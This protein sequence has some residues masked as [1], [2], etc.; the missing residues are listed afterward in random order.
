MKTIHR[1][2]FDRRVPLDKAEST[3]TLALIAV[4]A[5]HGQPNV[6][7]SVQYLF[8]EEKHACVI[9]GDNEIARQTALIFTQ[10]LINEF[11][12]DTFHVRRELHN[13]SAPAHECECDGRSCEG[14]C[15][16]GTA[17]GA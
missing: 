14:A 17:V 3:L 5:L 8:G 16:C 2:Q 12:E 7:L 13:T 6:R 1:F 15:T 4:E 9:D 11:G 10:F